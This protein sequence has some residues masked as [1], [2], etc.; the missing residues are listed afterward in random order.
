ME[1]TIPNQQNFLQVDEIMQRQIDEM[2]SNMNFMGI[3]TIILGAISCIGI[4]SAAY[5]IPLIFAGIRLRESAE[6]F[7]AYIHTSDK[8]AL[9]AAFSKQN[10]FF[11]ILKVLAIIYL[12][13]FAVGIIF[14]I[15]MFGIFMTAI[16]GSHSM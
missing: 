5:G 13:L 8:N 14:F 9:Y 11:F 10:R 1:E 6:A 7:R 2:A 16:M 4:L 12:L 15:S 3:L